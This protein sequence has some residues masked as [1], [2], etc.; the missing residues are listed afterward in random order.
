MSSTGVLLTH[1]AGSN[2]ETPL[3]RRLDDDLTAVG[4]KVVRYTLPFRVKR[5]KGPPG[6]GDGAAD[7]AGLAEAIAALGTERVFIGGHSYGGRMCSMLLAEQPSLAAGLITLAYPLHPPGKPEQR[8]DAHFPALRVPWLAVMGDRDEFATVEEMRS[9]PCELCVL[10][11]QG[12]GLQAS[13]AVSEA[14]AAW[15]AQR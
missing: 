12:H 13:A 8:R 6:R 2:A 14:V 3:L 9:A 7:R 10:A 11:G 1:G 4:Y 5:P 15:L